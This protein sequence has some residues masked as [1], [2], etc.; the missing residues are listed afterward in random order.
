ME[1]LWQDIRYGLR[2]LGKSPSFTI[3]AIAA[4]ALGIGAN[5]AIFS[6][7]YGIILKPLPYQ[8]PN[9]L[10]FVQ[11]HNP[12]SGI[13]PL[14][15]TVPARYEG[16][17]DRNHVFENLAGRRTKNFNITVD[18]EP[19]RVLGDQIT[20]NYFDTLGVKPLKGRFFFKEEDKAGNAQVVILREGY[21]Q[22]RF[23]GNIDVIG[24]QITVNNNSYTIV[25]IAPND[26]RNNNFNIFV[27]LALEPEKEIRGFHNLQVIG[28]LKSG[29]SINQAEAEIKTIAEAQVQEDPN[30]NSGWTVVVTPM[31]EV[32]V[33]D[34]RPAL[35]ILLSAVFLV[36]MIACANVANLILVRVTIREREVAIRAA[37]GAG[38]LRLAQQFFTESLLLSLMGGVLGILLANLLVTIFIKWNLVLLPRASEIQI[39]LPVLF[40]TVLVSVLT[41]VVLGLVPV[42][43]ASKTNL[44]EVMKENTHTATGWRGRKISN[45][46]IVSEVALS[47]VL[48]IGAG[49]LIRSFMKVQQ[50]DPGF[51]PD[52]VLTTQF[53]L[54][55]SVYQDGDKQLNFHKQFIEKTSN[56]PGVELAATSTSV[57]LSGQNPKIR[58]SVEGQQIDFNNTPFAASADIT[59]EYFKVMGIPLIKGRF[60]TD[61]DN[62]S[63]DKVVIVNQTM[64]E[65][66]FPGQDPIGKRI[67]RGVPDENETPEWSQIIGVVG[68]VK[69]A[70]LSEKFESQMY[71]PFYQYPQDFAL[72]ST[73]FLVTRT[74]VDP[75]SLVKGVREQALSID[76]DLPMFNTKI[77][78]QMVSDS[79]TYARFL[80]TLLGIFAFSALILASV[81]IYGV[82]SYSVA[83]RT[84]E[85]GIRLALGAQTFDIMKM[86]LKEGLSLTL[87]G[88]GV[89]LGVSLA[90]NHLMSNL[91]YGVT[92]TDP[93]TYVAIILIL[94]TI[95]LMA[96]YLPANRATRVDPIVALRRE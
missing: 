1:T 69:M 25:G 13:P 85:I 36:L 37:L 6:I 3:I 88:I 43:Q 87:L 63:S 83:Q 23:G 92:T 30:V 32:I 49:L 56:L 24:Q 29:V 84:H 82:I 20:Y 93:T 62:V 35:M 26:H 60:F 17:R 44:G 7:I 38:R 15:V 55:G 95:T 58:Y 28:R 78:S 31:H 86:V 52:N 10:V 42:F 64:A 65:K 77:L 18:K 5:T 50:V 59:P 34:V 4:L 51:N 46:L 21:W 67:T 89:G 47:L 71:F 2:M 68:D 79:L 57:P 19:E 16:W 76:K 48:L 53:A 75:N 73:F 54:Q 96:I 70:Q 80:M 61:Q 22:E 94:I 33:K 11:S 45:I 74:K 66:I 9:S 41:G 40:F 90:L 14:T 8:D 72:R 39:N 12:T 27:P 91:L 81:G